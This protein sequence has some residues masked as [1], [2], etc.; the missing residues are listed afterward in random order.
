VTR[1]RLSKETIK[2]MYAE[3]QAAADIEAPF[4]EL[5]LASNDIAVVLGTATFNCATSLIR[6]NGQDLLS[7]TPPRDGAAFPTLNGVFCDREGRE[8]FRVADN[9]WQG[10]PDAWD[11]ELV[12]TTVTIR[13]EQ[14]RP[15]L[16]FE[17]IPPKTIRVKML[18]MY[19][20]NCHIVCDEHQLLVGQIHGARGIYIG[21]ARFGCVGA[22]VGV[23]VNS[24]AAPAPTGISIVGGQGISI[25]GTGINVAVGASSMHILEMSVW[26]A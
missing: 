19:I 21:L 3:V 4:E 24:R 26:A 18:D 17:I 5:D 13:A 22:K 10:P 8:I 7:I 25:D 2:A 1:G 23:S 20:G 16:S 6:I 9:V 12:G 14:H 15:A 11:I